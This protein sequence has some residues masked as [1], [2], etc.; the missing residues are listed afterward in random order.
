MEMDHGGWTSGIGERDWR[1][2]M[3]LKM[4]SRDTEQWVW[5]VEGGG[6]G[7]TYPPSPESRAVLICRASQGTYLSS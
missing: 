3:E 2:A 7:G 4:E 5:E 6:S 1:R